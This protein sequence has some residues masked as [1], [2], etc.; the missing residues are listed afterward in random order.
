MSDNIP[1]NALNTVVIL[2]VS[3]L[4]DCGTG[5]V[6]YEYA[7]PLP[8]DTCFEGEYLWHDPAGGRVRF[9]MAYE[10]SEPW[11]RDELE[12]RVR[13]GGRNLGSSVPWEYMEF[14]SALIYAWGETQVI[15]EISYPD[16]D[17]R[18]VAATLYLE[19]ASSGTA[20]NERNT[21]TVQYTDPIDPSRSPPPFVL[22]R[23]LR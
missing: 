14:A 17:M 2:L 3:T 1:R 19:P 13:G 10:G 20:C 21:L 22:N 8:R 12:S 18:D 4:V 9:W 23:V 7:E 16:H 5:A 6:F 11:Y 15:L